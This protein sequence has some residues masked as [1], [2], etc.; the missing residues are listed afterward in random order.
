MNNGRTL[1]KLPIGLA[2]AAATLLICSLRLPLWQLRME[3]PQYRDEEALKVAVYPGNL[4]GDLNEITVLNQYI[5][6]HIPSALPQ[7]SWMPAA[8]VLAGVAGMGGAFC[9]ARQR[10]WGLTAVPVLLS[11]ALLGAAVQAQRQMH[12]IGH[13]RDAKTKLVGVKDF[14]P[15]LLGSV[16]IAQFNVV[17]RFGLGAYLVGAALVMQGAA[18]WLSGGRKSI[19]CSEQ[20]TATG[21]RAAGCLQP[22]QEIISG[23]ANR[24]TRCSISLL[25]NRQ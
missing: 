24:D 12:D 3:A 5:G 2:L 4:R 16:R 13:K 17:S 11:V 6:V 20:N 14:S 22:Q 10:R 21:S 1:R 23:D 7:L 9:R 25:P 8:L 19:C 18:A 15:P